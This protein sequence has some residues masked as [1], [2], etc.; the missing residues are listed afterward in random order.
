MHC[1]IGGKYLSFFSEFWF[2][3]FQILS[4]M[5]NHFL[6]LPSACQLLPIFSL[7]R[8]V[9]RNPF[10]HVIHRRFFTA[11]HVIYLVQTYLAHTKVHGFGVC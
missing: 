8:Q 11:G 4:Y 3:K 5:T 6:L 1:I 9:Q 2:M 7:I 10:L